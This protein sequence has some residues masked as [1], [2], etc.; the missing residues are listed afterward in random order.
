MRLVLITMYKAF[1][2]PHL[3]YENLIYDEAYNETFHQSLE[4][5]QDNACLSLSAA[6]RGSREIFYHELG[7]KS[8]QHQY[9]CRKLCLFYKIFKENKH[10]YLFNL[11]P[12]K[13]LDYNIRNT[14][15][16]TLFH[17]K[18]NFFKIIFLLLFIHRY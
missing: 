10:I 18:H 4:S 15:K 5:I 16:I 17:T 3:D 13:K 9:W 12:T 11:M 8:L 6:I 2:K 7:L 1:V 14:D